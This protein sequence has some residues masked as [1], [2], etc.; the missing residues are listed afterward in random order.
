MFLFQ[1]LAGEGKEGLHSK[2]SYWKSPDFWVWTQRGIWNLIQGILEGFLELKIWMDLQKRYQ[3]QKVLNDHFSLCY[4][5]EGLLLLFLG[6]VFLVLFQWANPVI[7]HWVQTIDWECIE[8][9]IAEWMDL[10][11]LICLLT[12]FCICWRLYRPIS[13]RVKNRFIPIFKGY[14]AVS[15]GGNNP[16]QNVTSSQ[17]KSYFLI[18]AV[19]LFNGMFACQTGLDLYY[20]LFNHALPEGI[21]YAEYAHQGAYPLLVCTLISGAFIL[22][23]FTSERSK[24]PHPM[25]Q[26]TMVGVGVWI[27]QNILLVGSAA[28]RNYQY[29]EI[30]SM[31]HLR[32][33]AMIWMGLIA[34]GFCWLM[35][36]FILN[37]NNRWWLQMNAMTVW[38]VFYGCCFCDFNGFIAQYNINQNFEGHHKVDYSSR[39][40]VDSHDFSKEILTPALDVEYMETTLGV[41]SLPAVI[42]Y[43]SHTSLPD[44]ASGYNN[45]SKLFEYQRMT[46]LYQVLKQQLAEEQK[47]WRSWNY[48]KWLLSNLYWEN[49]NKQ[50]DFQS[51][52]PI[53]S[54][55]F[56][57]SEQ[58]VPHNQPAAHWV[59][60]DP[61]P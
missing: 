29:I 24:A 50:N 15:P 6:G 42:H 20:L 36:R 9:S 7:A 38:W 26:I 37:Y 23:V 3:N 4:W 30:Y 56:S 39:R 45:S 57:P 51:Y 14:C 58:K 61:A 34:L 35:L 22:A 41:E 59:F 19:V 28:W 44:E 32:L 31:T 12:V 60:E 8:K 43:L 17:R 33:F 46:R 25:H 5:G 48:Q 40:P 47:D 54:Q 21:T 27:F 2:A 13:Q 16:F 18:V 52:T 53:P 11:K 1:G 10:P 49:P 55:G